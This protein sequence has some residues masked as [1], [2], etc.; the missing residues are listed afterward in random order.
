MPR[1]VRLIALVTALA[2]SSGSH[3]ISLPDLGDS[4][5]TALS[6]Q[7]ERALG[8]QT[9]T[10]LRASGAMLNDPEINAY[11]DALGHRL[12]AA[13]PDLTGQHFSFFAIDSNELNAFAL[14]GGYIGVHTGL[15]AATQ[16][17]SEL[18]S[19]LAH[20][21]SHVS[22]HHIARQIA[23]QSSTQML[24]MAA[25]VAAIL[26]AGTGN[27]QAAMAAATGATAAQQQSMINYTRE[28]E[29]EAD[30]IGFQLLV[31]AGF[32]PRAMAA[33]FERLQQNTRLVDAGTTP[34][35]L[36]THPLTAQR[37]AEAEDRAFTQPYR[38]VPDSQDYHLARALVRSY[39]GQ[40]RDA[41]QRLTAEL[42][43][44][45]YRDR[46]AARYG[47]AAAQLRASHF[48]AAEAT[49][50]G[51]ARDGFRHPMLEALAGQILSQSG[52]SDAARARYEAAL[53]RY[54][55]HLQLVYDYPALLIKSGD[56]KTA[57]A[58]I[59]AQLLVR[60]SD[61]TLHQQA[62][63]AWAAL[64][65]P[66]KSHRHQGEFYALSGSNKAA[67]EQF[68]L[69]LKSTRDDSPEVQIVEARLQALRARE[70]E[71]KADGR[72]DGRTRGNKPEL[73]LYPHLPADNRH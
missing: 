10:S 12:V 49:V 69:A 22:Q 13:D 52:R 62:A 53:K 20:E 38:Q 7:S 39:E 24:S 73:S 35:W 50:D 42:A 45:R 18:A 71:D 56:F 72:G 61:A 65:S 48:A 23:A 31:R 51:L 46:I 67:M 27:G 60:P 36:R 17:E 15:I 11:L 59:D 16:S 43:E 6:R 41:E 54:P 37:V 4:A 21:I 55:D 19:V 5:E 30:R 33:F 64:G 66:L 14:P 70:R 32:D 63:E 68:Q 58:F 25:M 40:P 8:E 44:G 57:A 26:A 47:L 1:R 28:H 2:W 9:M 29:Q 34:A 3:A